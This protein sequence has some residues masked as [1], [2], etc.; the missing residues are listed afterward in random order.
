[1]K[2]GGSTPL[3]LFEITEGEQTQYHFDTNPDY[4]STT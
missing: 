3:Y 2:W 4:S 1:M